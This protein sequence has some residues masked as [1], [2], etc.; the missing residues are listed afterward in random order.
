MTRFKPIATA[1]LLAA[2]IGS[3]SAQTN[4]PAE[5]GFGIFT[6]T[7]GPAAAYGMPGKNAADLMIDDINAKAA[8]KG[9]R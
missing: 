5:I 1:L 9:F 8:L 6:F 7:S 2:A 3:A 4:K